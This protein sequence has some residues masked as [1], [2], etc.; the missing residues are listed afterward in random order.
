MEQGTAL[1]I[2]APAIA[3]ALLWVLPAI[4]AGQQD[5]RAEPSVNLPCPECGT[6]YAIRENRRE[7]AP[8]TTPQ[9]PLPVGPTIRFSLGDKADSR[10]HLDIYGSP[11]MREAMVERYYE[12]VIRFDDGRWGRIEVSDPAGMKPGDRVHVHRN[13]IESPDSLS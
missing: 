3:A 4:G 7:R 10:P 11:S 9:R 2:L 13:R 8:A 5:G 12:V 6:I 1:R